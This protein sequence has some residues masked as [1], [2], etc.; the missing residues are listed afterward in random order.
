M[1]RQK[2]QKAQNVRLPGKL[3]NQSDVAFASDHP[4]W[5]KVQGRCTE[6]ASKYIRKR[7]TRNDLGKN[8]GTRTTHLCLVNRLDGELVDWLHETTTL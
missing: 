5:N 8:G 2:A 4:Q 3:A 6:G 1:L 7:S